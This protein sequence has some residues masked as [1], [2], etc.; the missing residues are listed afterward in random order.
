MKIR[1]KKKTADRPVVSVVRTDGSTTSGRLGANDFGA[2]HDLAHYVVESRLALANGFFGLLAQGWNIPDFEVRGASSRFPD[3][4]LVVEC[5]VGQ[6][7][8]VVFSAQPVTVAEFNWL[9]SQAVGAVRP[10]VSAPQFD[11]AEFDRLREEFVALV[12]RW[13]LLP[14]GETLELDFPVTSAAAR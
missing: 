9:V 14:A 2:V 6:L 13:R 1:L 10:A 3:E 11:A 4:A 8:Q 12:I 7:T 5:V